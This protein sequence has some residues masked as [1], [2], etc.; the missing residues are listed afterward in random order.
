M[1]GGFNGFS[2]KSPKSF[3]RAIGLESDPLIGF[4]SNPQYI[5]VVSSTKPSTYRGI[6]QP[7]TIPPKSGSSSRRPSDPA[8]GA[9]AS[10]PSLASPR[11]KRAAAHLVDAIHVL[12]VPLVVLCAMIGTDRTDGSIWYLIET[13]SK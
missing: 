2:G 4:Y 7:L 13:A 8:P 5:W 1:N 6:S 10:C 12:L 11:L 3:P 9:A